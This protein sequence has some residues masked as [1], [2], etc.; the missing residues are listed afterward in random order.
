MAT[1]LS[2]ALLPHPPAPLPAPPPPQGTPS[3]EALKLLYYSLM[4]RFHLH[5]GNYLEVCRCYR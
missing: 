5:E 1:K 4:I 2:P 3:L